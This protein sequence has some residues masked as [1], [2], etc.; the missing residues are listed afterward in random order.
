MEPTSRAARAARSAPVE[1]RRN[2]GPAARAGEGEGRA[3]RRDVRPQHGAARRRRQAL[4][5]GVGG[6]DG[7]EGL[8]AERRAAAYGGA[9]RALPSGVAV[10]GR[11]LQRPAARLGRELVAEGHL[12]VPDVAD[13][14][15]SWPPVARHPASDTI[16]SVFCRCQHDVV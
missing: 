3:V 6:R 1:R 12:P 7:A 2:A 11:Q 14:A 15:V 16:S 8:R 4:R 5:D 10:R 9:G 13:Q